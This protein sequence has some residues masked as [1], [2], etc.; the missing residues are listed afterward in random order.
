[1]G[2]HRKGIIVTSREKEK[3]GKR[4]K[5]KRLLRRESST[6]APQRR[7]SV[8]SGGRDAC[9]FCRR[10]GGKTCRGGEHLIQTPRGCREKREWF[11]R[12]GKKD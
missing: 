11:E 1:M 9:K 2:L 4:G 7:P 3:W 12:K 8:T 5:K 6:N 10:K